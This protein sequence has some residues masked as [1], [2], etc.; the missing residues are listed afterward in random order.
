MINSCFIVHISA[1]ISFIKTFGVKIESGLVLDSLDVCLLQDSSCFSEDA[2]TS[3]NST[4]NTCDIEVKTLSMIFEFFSISRS[5]EKIVSRSLF[6]SCWRKTLCCIVNANTSSCDFFSFCR[7]KSKSD[8]EDELLKL[9]SLEWLIGLGFARGNSLS[10]LVSHSLISE[11]SM[12]SCSSEENANSSFFKE[13]IL[14][15]AFEN[16]KEMPQRAKKTMSNPVNTLALSFIPILSS[17]F[18]SLLTLFE[19]S[20]LGRWAHEV[21]HFHE[22]GPSSK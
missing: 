7:T 10:D 11:G 1:F 14:L 15:I 12:L 8:S 2:V 17:L 4:P 5:L 16:V 20:L 6:I 13:F 18:V 21:E 9:P 22:K 19:S 3:E